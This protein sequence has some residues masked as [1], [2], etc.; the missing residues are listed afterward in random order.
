M[1]LPSGHS[2]FYR[3]KSNTRNSP[4]LILLNGLDQDVDSWQDFIGHLEQANGDVGYLT[5][6]MRGMG[7]SLEREMI[8]SAFAF[9]TFANLRPIEYQ[10]QT[11]D[12]KLMIERLNLKGDLFFVG[13]SYGAAIILDF[14]AKNQGVARQAI[15][16]SPYLAPLPQQDSLIRQQ[17]ALVRQ[18]PANPLNVLPEA[19][20]YNLFLAPIVSL[21]P[22]FEPVLLQK[23]WKISGVY[24]MVEGA[25]HFDALVTA[26]KLSPNSI[27]VLWAEKDQYLARDQVINFHRHAPQNIF[28]SE[29]ILKDAHHDLVRQVPGYLAAFALKALSGTL[30]VNGD[31]RITAYPFEGYAESARERWE[32][33]SEPRQ[34]LDQLYLSKFETF[35]S[36]ITWRL[37]DGNG[38]DCDHRLT[39]R[40]R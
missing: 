25:R 3:H 27:H 4:T 39:P 28:A 33:P 34:L 7:K 8:N 24:R 18:Q 38:N 40:P 19:R 23:P 12:L 30:P 1:D 20:L 6:D 14:M 22:L 9:K 31:R 29:S 21:Y 16:A 10:E 11:E 13:I 17:I 2:L 37:L 26:K 35:F 5:Y 15:L 32:F 36:P